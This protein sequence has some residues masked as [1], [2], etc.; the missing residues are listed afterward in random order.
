MK[1]I[2]N[3]Y[4]WPIPIYLHDPIESRDS[5]LRNKR[6]GWLNHDTVVEFV[7]YAKYIAWKFEDLADMFSIMNEPNVVCGA[8][9]F[10]PPKAGFPPQV[11]PALRADFSRKSMR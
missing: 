6:N 8:G 7:K 11:F 10:N 3:A 4:H 1:L 9:Y 2:I 5:G